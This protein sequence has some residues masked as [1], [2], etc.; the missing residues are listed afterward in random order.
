MN[1]QTV[2]DFHIAQFP[3]QP[4]LIWI[5]HTRHDGHVTEL[6]GAFS[7]IY[8]QLDFC[9]DPFRAY[10]ERL[11]GIIW[12]TDDDGGDWSELVLGRASPVWVRKTRPHYFDYVFKVS[13][14]AETTESD[15]RF[16]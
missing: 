11:S 16:L 8:V 6:A 13:E 10:V 2:T 5:K 1:I 3:E 12:W 9:F 15:K 4:K 7:D 14:K